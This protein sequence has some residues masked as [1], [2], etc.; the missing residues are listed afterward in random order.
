V[1]SL[2]GL[3]E[4]DL[5]RLD[6]KLLHPTQRHDRAWMYDP[7][8]VRFLLGRRAPAD[9]RNSKDASGDVT[10]AVFGLFEEGKTLP[11]VVIATKQTAATVA[12]L[13]RQYDG[14][15][16]AATLGGA[17]VSKLRRLLDLPDDGLTDHLT[18]VIEA[19]LSERYQAGYRD[20]CEEAQDCGEIVDPTTGEVRKVA[21]N[22][23]R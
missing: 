5:G 4:E 13:R 23:R 12:E 10:A 11:Q 20:G 1:A 18:D 8:E 3:T 6:G 17:T 14:M 7:D 19:R 2:V 16:G 9:V 22:A 21:A 15:L